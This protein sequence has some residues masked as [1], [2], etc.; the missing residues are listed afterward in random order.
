M[1]PATSIFKILSAVLFSAMIFSG[2][3]KDKFDDPKP[4]PDTDPNLEVNL[5]IQQLKDLYKGESVEITEDYTI[6]GIVI[7][8]DQAGNVYQTLVIQD[9][10]GGIGF[11]VQR[12]DLF[13]DFPFGRKVYV[14]L[15]GLW[16]G[17]YNGL[18]QVGL[19]DDGQGSVTLI[20]AAFV[21][22]FFVKGPRNQK[23]EPL[24]IS[25]PDL[26]SKYQ[27]MLIKLKDVQFISSEAGSAT[28]ADAV[29]KQTENTMLEDCD[30][31]QIIV[32]T[33]GYATFAG[34]VV[35][36]GKGDVVAIYQIFRTD[37]QLLLNKVSDVN[38]TQAR[39][40]EDEVPSG[41][42]LDENYTIAQLKNLY[43]GSAIEITEDYIV[44]GTVISSDEENN[45]FQLLV[46]Q[47]GQDGIGFRVQ[48][49]EL[50]RAYPPGQIVK[51]KL[52]GLWLGA[53]NDLMQVG[54]SADQGG[55][56][57]LI[58]SGK[59]N[60]HFYKGD[61]GIPVTPLEISVA[62]LDGQKHQNT[63]V[64]L[65]DVQF[66]SGQAG[67]Q[68]YA[69]AIN[70]Q[71][72]NRNLE[73]CD[74][75]KVVVRTSGHANFAG[76]KLPGG[77]GDAVGIYQVFKN[78]HQLLL[79]KAGDVSLNGER[80][81]G[82]TVDP[83]DPEDPDAPSVPGSGAQ[84]LFPGADFENWTLF[85]EQLTTHGIKDYAVQSQGTGY[86][87]SHALSINGKPGGNDYVFTT[88]GGGYPSGIDKL[89]F[90]VKGTS[91]KSLSVN[92]YNESGDYA[93]FNV[94]N[95]TSN[96]LVKAAP[97]NQY[98]GTIDTKGE[99]VLVTLDLSGADLNTSGSG[100]VFAIKVG[101]D[102]DYAL[103]IDEI[104]VW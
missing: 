27:N 100:S 77:K 21:D 32:R 10:T 55:G 37:N 75:G 23:V 69:D 48:K 66:V 61:M 76:D 60:S 95:L 8:D 33:S 40:G 36:D 82:G 98:T 30:G 34:D 104:V 2:C 25:I 4:E 62:N 102:V 16:I 92:I 78:D 88:Q 9:E 91:G 43:N 42:D 29:K 56:V 3:I 103:M 70:K 58:S 11:R 1:K 89:S 73:D 97:N 31:N 90:Y 54:E 15:K 52:K 26:S 53:Y 101:R 67:T 64:R 49:S 71:T 79:N 22:D 57:T 19:G 84:L 59:I 5:T 20:P 44:S 24:E 46:L 83:E 85:L 38:L 39:C 7:S 47:D 94:E 86:N 17:A 51:V 87:G 6:S 93:T 50:Y 68:T 18:N 99:W 35:P 65:K 74:G 14:K 63:L 80:C 28:Y 96:K 13:T 41:S 81:D 72:Q 45:V 12:T